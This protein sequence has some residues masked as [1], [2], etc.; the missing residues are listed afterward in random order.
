MNWSTTSARWARSGLVWLLLTMTFGLYLG[1]TGQYGRTSAH[2]HAG[3]LG[4]LWSI[5][6]ATLYARATAA[7]YDGSRI[8]ATQW[9]LFNLGVALHVVALWM[10]LTQGGAWGMVVGLAGILLLA[11]TLWIVATLWPWLAIRRAGRNDASTTW[12]ND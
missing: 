4:G 10:V 11:T 8:P 2:A 1:I 6:F 7:G 9:A 5:A 3:L 12:G